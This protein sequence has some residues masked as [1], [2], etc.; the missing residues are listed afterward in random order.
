MA[1]KMSN[2]LVVIYNL[3]DKSAVEVFPIDANDLVKS[4]GYSYNNPKVSKPTN[5][6]SFENQ[7][8]I[9]EPD[10]GEIDLESMGRS[11]L[12]EYAEK[13]FNEELNSRYGEKRLRIE[14]EKLIEQH[15][16]QVSNEDEEDE[17]DLDGDE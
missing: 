3:E 6:V 11:E 8:Q 10:I 15:K 13:T 12:L 2:G 17:I 4:G 5:K 14:I 7:D 16:N 1:R 9:G